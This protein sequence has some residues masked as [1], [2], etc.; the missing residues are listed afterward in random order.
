MSI[1]NI[2]INKTDPLC[3]YVCAKQNGFMKKRMPRKQ[4]DTRY[5]LCFGKL[6]NRL[7]QV[8]VHAD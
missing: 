1:N 2:I 6:Y 3:Q 7:E 5:F 4:R 8:A